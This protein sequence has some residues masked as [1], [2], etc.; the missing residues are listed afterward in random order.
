[1][2]NLFVT[3]SGSTGFHLYLT[4]MKNLKPYLAIASLLCLATLGRAEDSTT[5]PVSTTTTS[6][7][8]PTASAAPKSIAPNGEEGEIRR[9]EAEVHKLKHEVA[10]LEHRHHHH[11]H[12]HPVAGAPV[13]APTNGT[14]PTSTGPS[15][16]GTSTVTGA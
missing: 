14:T 8:N 10:E 9:L 3:S 6:P 2:D 15:T 12:H 4:P 1:M 11:H 16:T 13:A 7:F 5:T